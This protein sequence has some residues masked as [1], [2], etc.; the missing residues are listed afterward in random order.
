MDGWSFLERIFTFDRKK[1]SFDFREEI[2]ISTFL[3]DIRFKDI[4]TKIKN[5]MQLRN[6]G[7]Y[8]QALVEK[9]PKVQNNQFKVVSHTVQYSKAPMV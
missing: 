1:E 2:E 6:N 4:N 8:K 5:N 3:A 7:K 9:I